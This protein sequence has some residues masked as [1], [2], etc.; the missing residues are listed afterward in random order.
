V[1]PIGVWAILFHH[2]FWRESKLKQF[3]ANLE[4][5]HNKIADPASI[6]YKDRKKSLIDRIFEYFVG[7][8]LIKPG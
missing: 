5:L 1:P 8:T 6:H 3:K 7:K 4:K 2:N